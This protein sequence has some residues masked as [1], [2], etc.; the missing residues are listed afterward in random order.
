MAES[1]LAKKL[2]IKPGH[3]MLVMNASAGYLEALA[4]LPRDAELR[5]SADGAFDFV[6]VF[7]YN[8]ADI[9]AYTATALRAL[10]PGGLLWFSYR[11]KSSAVATDITRDRGWDSVY[12]AGF[13]PVTQ[14]AIDDQWT[15]FRFRPV[16]D[17]K[18][19]KRA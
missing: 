1:A 16:S 6:Q 7:V 17:V 15:G 12:G 2:G 13:R 9:D 19:R 10:K 11:K 3:R 14:I 5:P 18:P 4:P 8:K